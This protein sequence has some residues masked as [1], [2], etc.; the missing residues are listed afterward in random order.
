MIG[1]TGS[2]SMSYVQNRTL[3]AKSR[4]FR[5]RAASAVKFLICSKLSLDF[6]R[7]EQA[8]EDQILDSY[9]EKV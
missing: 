2:L 1:D 4:V 5:G 7:E 3:V 9:T 6:A 8:R